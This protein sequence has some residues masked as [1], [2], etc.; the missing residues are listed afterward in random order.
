MNKKITKEDYKK[1]L[2]L[3]SDYELQLNQKFIK[4]Y[5]CI[6]CNKN[7]IKPLY[8]EG[9][10]P[11]SQENDM[12]NNGNVIYLCCGYGSRFDSDSYYFGLCDDCLEKGL[13]NN[14]VIDYKELSKKIR[15]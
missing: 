15:E 5:V 8:P 10:N 2:E 7:K 14:K 6:A 4:D 3:I 13:E 12:W 9:V 11:L 1:A